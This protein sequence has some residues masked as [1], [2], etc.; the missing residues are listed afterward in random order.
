MSVTSVATEVQ[1]AENAPE[2]A[3]QGRS[4]W[5]LTWRRL[6]SDKVAVASLIVIVIMVALAIAAPAFAALTGHPPDVA[7]PNTGESAA[8]L[9]VSPGTN[10]FILGTDG[11]GRDLLVRILYGARISLFVGIVTTLIATVA[12]VTVGM[13]AGYFGGVVDAVL[14]RFVD[15]VLAFPY[16]VLALALAVVLGPSLTVILGVISFFTWAGISR[17]V[18]G[19]T[20]FDQGEGVHR[21][22]PVA[23]GGAV[24]HHVR[25][26]PAQPAGPGA[27]ARHAVHPAGHHL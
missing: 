5:Q 10:G 15:A 3:I 1:G 2:Q 23:R 17:I 20:L 11:S 16:V 9:P 25:A 22:G 6:L 14:S 7:Y 21:G 18:R 12:G 19:Q 8:G 13:I 26:H 4:Q 24:P 27:R